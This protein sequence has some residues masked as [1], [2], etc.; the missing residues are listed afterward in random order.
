MYNYG[1]CMYFSIIIKRANL[2]Y[3]WW[4]LEKPFKKNDYEWMTNMKYSTFLQ[5]YNHLW[6]KKV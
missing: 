4:L 5:T 3:L 6:H 2:L 1:N